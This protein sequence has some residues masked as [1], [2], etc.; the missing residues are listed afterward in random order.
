MP[1]HATADLI[2]GV[3]LCV[4]ACRP[5]PAEII[6]A[7]AN[8]EG[9]VL[10]VDDALSGQVSQIAPCAAPLE[11]QI[12]RDPYDAF[13]I[14]FRESQLVHIPP[15]QRAMFGGAEFFCSSRESVPM[16][17]FCRVDGSEMGCTPTHQ[18]IATTGASVTHPCTW[19]RLDVT[20]TS[21]ISTTP[22]IAPECPSAA[23]TTGC[24]VGSGT[25]AGEPNEADSGALDAG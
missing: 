14:R 3:A 22:N 21:S 25:D 4:Q 12:R 19:T 16:C 15:K 20:A 8:Q 24:R 7:W 17:Q 13:A 18:K 10:L 9:Q 6:G 23:G 2:W 1:R 5:S 11:I